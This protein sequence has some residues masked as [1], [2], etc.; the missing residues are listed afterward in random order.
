MLDLNIYRSFILSQSRRL[1][2]SNK[3]GLL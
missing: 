2:P 1:D 3:L